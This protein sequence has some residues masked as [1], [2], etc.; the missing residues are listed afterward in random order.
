[1]ALVTAEDAYAA[2][3]SALERLGDHEER[4]GERFEQIKQNQVE[5]KAERKEMHAE[6]KTVLAAIGARVDRLYGRAWL[7]VIVFGGGC[8]TVIGVL[9][10]IIWEFVQAGMQP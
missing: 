8:L 9:L 5:A 1:M 3:I 7:A 2:A 6:N 10:K 4:D